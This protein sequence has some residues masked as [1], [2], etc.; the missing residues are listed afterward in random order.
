M[1]QYHKVFFIAAPHW[2]QSAAYRRALAIARRSHAALHIGMFLEPRLGMPFL[3]D[4]LRDELLEQCRVDVERDAQELRSTGMDVTC[5]TLWSAE[6][7]REV[8]D[9]VATLKADLV[10]K[11]VHHE[12]A[13][14]RVFV[15]PLDYRLLRACQAP[16]HLVAEALNPLP[17]K[18]AAA[19]DVARPELL[20]SGL[21]EGIIEAA[22][23]LASLC[24]AEL[25]F[26]HACDL[27]SAIDYD[28]ATLS[29]SWDSSYAEQVRISLYR[30]FNHL[31]D[32]WQ[33]PMEHRHFV[34]GPATQGIA[35][36]MDD[37]RIDVVVMGMQSRLG[38]DRILGSTTERLLY[39]MSGGM[40]AVGADTTGHPRL[41]P[42]SA[43]PS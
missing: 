2:R 35:N 36:F 1:D 13:L 18:V 33:V 17:L 7:C 39:R 30:T 9:R 14:R 15:T 29:S 12:A 34:L 24:G 27:P 22:R 32:R 37:H 21:N 38:L 40:L 19:L 41:P 8:L 20:T 16:L 5:E 28:S 31:A 6:P 4:H 43:E 23:N 10:I 11:N 26:L 25:H 42:G 3:S